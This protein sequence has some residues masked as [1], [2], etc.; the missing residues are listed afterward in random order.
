MALA[1]LNGVPFPFDPDSVGWSFEVK[2]HVEDTIGGRVVQVLGT[3][4]GDMTVSGSFGSGGWEQQ[5]VFYR[6]VAAWVDRQNATKGRATLRFIYT[7]KRWDLHV[8]I[9][10][11]Q[12]GQGA[13][14]ITHDNTIIAPRYTLLLF[15][16]Q[17][18][19]GNIVRGIQ[20]A[21]I[22]RLVEGVGWKF[23]SDYNGPASMGN[24]ATV[25]TAFQNAA[26]G[27]ATLPGGSG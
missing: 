10:A 26:A 19:V 22:S 25:L 2:T 13:S 3:R 17:D 5:Q 21:Y 9:R 24:E 7:P 15:V 12:D 16:V 6:R 8:L 4:L 27:T 1:T 11:L 20:D 14:G 23:S 18:N